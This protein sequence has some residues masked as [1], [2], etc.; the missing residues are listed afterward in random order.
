MPD[1]AFGSW[2]ARPQPRPRGAG[3]SSRRAWRSARI[4]LIAEI[5]DRVGSLATDQEQLRIS[6]RNAQDARTIAGADACAVQDQRILRG[7][8]R[9]EYVRGRGT[10]SPR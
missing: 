3:P 8:P 9:V 10:I 6:H 4:N 5:R 2:W 7:S 1:A